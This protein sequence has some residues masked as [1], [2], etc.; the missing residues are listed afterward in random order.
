MNDFYA[1]HQ[2]R[3][4][5]PMLTSLKGRLKE[6][7]SCV[8]QINT[9]DTPEIVDIKIQKVLNETAGKIK[10]ENL[11]GCF[12]INAINDFICTS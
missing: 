7:H 9:I 2:T 8:P 11:K 4:Y 10:N 5:V 1:W 12:Y 6:I 3:D